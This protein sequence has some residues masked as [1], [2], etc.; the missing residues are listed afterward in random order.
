MRN[1]ATLLR[2][3]EPRRLDIIPLLGWDRTPLFV[4]LLR[5]SLWADGVIHQ[6]L[7]AHQILYFTIAYD[8]ML[9]GHNLEDRLSKGEE[10]FFFCFYFLKHIVDD[11]YSVISSRCSRTKHPVLRNDSDSQLDNV[12]FDSESVVTLSSVSSNLSLNS[13]CSSVSQNS[14]DSQDNNP[15]AVF[16]GASNENHEESHSNGYA[17]LS[18][19]I[20]TAFQCTIRNFGFL[21]TCVT[22]YK[23]FYP[24][25]VDERSIVKYIF[26]DETK[27]VD[28][29]SSSLVSD[30]APHRSSTKR[31]QSKTIRYPLFIN[32]SLLRIN[33]TAPYFPR[34]FN[35][36]FVFK[37]TRNSLLF[38][39]S[40][41]KKIS[42]WKENLQ[43]S[44]PLSRN[45]ERKNR[46]SE[47][48]ISV[49]KKAIAFRKIIN[50][51]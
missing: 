48:E 12:M 19:I 14:R 27:S 33:R 31:M 16:P 22:I 49:K 21:K 35:K 41:K 25:L 2:I 26:A 36:I 37:L 17:V 51:E 23:I 34:N 43:P 4:S 45:S 20:F 50:I 13:W 39:V 7:N 9:F 5:L 46:F 29:H 42:S 30:P 24:K 44:I 38:N 32:K 10:I 47:K 40:S 8:W 6:S 3:F 18:V 15:P 28:C 11:E 1:G